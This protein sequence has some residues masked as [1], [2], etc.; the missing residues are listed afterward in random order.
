MQLGRP[1][2][3]V[4]LMTDARTNLLGW[5]W[6]VYPD[7]HRNRK[8]L[9]LHALTVPVF[10]AGTVAAVTSPF[11]GAGAAAGGIVAMAVAM[12]A[13]GR[14]H[15]QETMPPAPFRGPLDVVARIFAEQWITF[16]RFVMSGGL[17]RALRATSTSARN[18]G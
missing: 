5:Q 8:N 6:A 9:W 13:Q 14:G 15:R 16:P 17:G 11:T 12:A 18:A 7:A 2:R 10:M 1:G 4:L 3:I